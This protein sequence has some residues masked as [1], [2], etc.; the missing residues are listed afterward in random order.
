MRVGYQC[1]IDFWL[2]GK[3]KAV[4]LVYGAA[5]IL[6]PTPNYDC[7]VAKNSGEEI[8]SSASHRLFDSSEVSFLLA[9]QTFIN[10]SARNKAFLLPGS[11]PE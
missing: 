4:P 11:T 10:P 9:L 2:Q 5:E 6:E 1:G 8:P 3:V 7:H